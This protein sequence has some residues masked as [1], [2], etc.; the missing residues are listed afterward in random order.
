MLKKVGLHLIYTRIMCD[1]D[2]TYEETLF[3]FEETRSMHDH[4]AEQP[5][6]EAVRD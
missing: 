5:N 2:V 3:E 1:L 4:E 6:R